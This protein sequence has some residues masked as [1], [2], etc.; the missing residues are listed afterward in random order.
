MGA[1]KFHPKKLLIVDAGIN[2]LK[3]EKSHWI[4]QLSL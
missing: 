2:T 3:T 4:K 1:F